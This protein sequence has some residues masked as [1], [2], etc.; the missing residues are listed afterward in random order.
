MLAQQLTA[1]VSRQCHLE[2]LASLDVED[3]E[4]ALRGCLLKLQFADACL[5]PARKG[6]L[7]IESA[8]QWRGRAPQSPAS[9]RFLARHS[10]C[11]AR[12]LPA[13]CSLCTL[14]TGLE[15]KLLRV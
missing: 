1:C 15:A 4:A 13:S 5:K 6:A 2:I 11:V 9:P 12:F 7:P 10:H 14:T 8:C 3:V